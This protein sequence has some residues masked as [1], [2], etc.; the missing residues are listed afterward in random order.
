MALR[1]RT[2]TLLSVRPVEAITVAVERIDKRT[3][4]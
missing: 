1:L 3:G 2:E 4:E